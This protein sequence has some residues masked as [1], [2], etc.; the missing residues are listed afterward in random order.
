MVWNRYP[1]VRVDWQAWR[2]R[3][4]AAEEFQATIPRVRSAMDSADATLFPW[5]RQHRYLQPTDCSLGESGMALL[6]LWEVEHG[7]DFPTTGSR[8][9][10]SLLVGF[11]SRLKA[12]V[13]RDD[14]LSRWLT[15]EVLYRP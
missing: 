11:T 7:R 8:D 10:A 13:S 6:I 2:R 12:R 5:L 4:E 3:Q 14:E 1:L 15:S 9:P